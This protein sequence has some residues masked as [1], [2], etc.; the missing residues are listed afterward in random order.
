MSK[1]PSPLKIEYEEV[2]LDLSGMVLVKQKEVGDVNMEHNLSRKVNDAL[3]SQMQAI[4]RGINTRIEH[5]PRIKVGGNVLDLRERLW[6]LIEEWRL[7]GDVERWEAA[8]AAYE[9]V[10]Y[11]GRRG[12]ND[13]DLRVC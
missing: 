2:D 8:W 11:A 7:R 4:I 10:Q 5:G 13:R 6:E 3:K 1:A 12:C 9:D